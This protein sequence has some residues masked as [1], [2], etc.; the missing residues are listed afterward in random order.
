LA[1]LRGAG[2]VFYPAVPFGES[3]YGP[4]CRV[5]A[6]YAYADAMLA[7]RQKKIAERPAKD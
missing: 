3:S 4:G 6:R 1:A 7:E 2:G 5:M